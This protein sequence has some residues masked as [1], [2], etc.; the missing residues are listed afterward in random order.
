MAALLLNAVEIELLACLNSFE[1]RYLVVGGHAVAYHGYLRS[2]KDLDLF[3]GTSIE[4]AG[5][6]VAALQ[7][8]R[9]NGA[10]LSAEKFS[11]PNKQIPLGGYYHTEL[12]TSVPGV[13]FDS[14]YNRRVPTFEGSTP[15]PVISLPDLLL[16]KRATARPQDLAD[17]EALANASTAV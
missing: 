6:V 4:N 14:A 10:D 17:I 13:D 11:Q 3:I 7:S 16:Q 5:R 12:L 1:V 9:F 8:L 2:M 15:I